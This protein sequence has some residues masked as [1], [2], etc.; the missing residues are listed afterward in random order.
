[1]SR[2]LVLTVL[3][4]ATAMLG[5]APS[6]QAGLANGPRLGGTG[7]ADERIHDVVSNGDDGCGRHAEHGP[8]RNRMPPCSTIAQP[9][10]GTMRWTVGAGGNESLVLPWVQ[11]FYRGWPCAHPVLA[12]EAKA[13]AWEEVV[14]T[15]SCE[16]R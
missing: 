11:H 15:P 2:W 9:V 12:P 6:L 1:M 14:T 10:T 4:T 8:L 7:L 13:V 3:S 16:T 5:C